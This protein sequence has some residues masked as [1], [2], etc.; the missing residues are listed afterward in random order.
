MIPEEYQTSPEH[1][2]V[3]CCLGDIES[4]S[5]NFFEGIGY[6]QKAADIY[7]K[8]FLDESK[9]VEYF[10]ILRAIAYAYSELNSVDESI[11]YFEKAKKAADKT[12]GDKSEAYLMCLFNLGKAYYKNGELTKSKNSLIAAKAISIQYF[13][14]KHL[15]N[16]NILKL[17]NKI[18]RTSEDS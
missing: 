9:P 12:G 8:L 4:F 3:L 17:L 14:E 10:Q 1:A 2:Y 16:N 7:S 18:S 11:E 13:S 5:E 6:Y 15:A